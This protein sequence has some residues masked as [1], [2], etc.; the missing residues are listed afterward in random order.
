MEVY[1]NHSLG[2][3]D[4]SPI[5]F[6]FPLHTLRQLVLFLVHSKKIIHAIFNNK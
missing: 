2:E 6:L 4:F 3:K 1:F 5:S